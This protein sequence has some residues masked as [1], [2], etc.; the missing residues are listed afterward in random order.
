M[1]SVLSD[2]R[3]MAPEWLAPSCRVQVPP[4]AWISADPES[5]EADVEELLAAELL[6]E[7]A[8]GA[9][10]V[11]SCGKVFR[12]LT[13]PCVFVGRA[14][15]QFR[16][17][18]GLLVAQSSRLSVAVPFPRLHV[19]FG[20]LLHVVVWA[21]LILC[22]ISHTILCSGSLKS[23]RGF[24]LATERKLLCSPYRIGSGCVWVLASLVQ[25]KVLDSALS[26][27]LHKFRKISYEIDLSFQQIPK[28]P[29]LSPCM[30]R[31]ADEAAPCAAAAAAGLG[32]GGR[33]WIH[34][35]LC[36]RK[37]TKLSAARLFLSTAS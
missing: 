28:R 32:P 29:D 26:S 17:L 16:A 13:M 14:H 12:S 7:R 36:T 1:L 35:L 25:L 22:R 27:F 5:S 31:G 21:L 24:R 30:G 19:F 34:A 15:V 10:S 37:M 9:V 23:S 8:K 6:K 2:A 4:Q 20:R 33:R 3:R 11:S 18:C